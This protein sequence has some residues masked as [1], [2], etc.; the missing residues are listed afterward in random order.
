ME[1][2]LYPAIPIGRGDDDVSLHTWLKNVQRA[3]A[4]ISLTNY[5]KNWALTYKHGFKVCHQ[6]KQWSLSNLTELFSELLEGNLHMRIF[7]FNFA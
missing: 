1:N 4:G 5:E 2:T 3:E 6:T 7:L